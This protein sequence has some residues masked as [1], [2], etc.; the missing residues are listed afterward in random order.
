MNY[1]QPHS[2]CGKTV[3]ITNAGSGFGAACAQAAYT[4]GANIVLIDSG[5]TGISATSKRFDPSRIIC[6][7]ANQAS[8]AEVQEVVVAAT[9]KFGG[10]DIAFAN[11]GSASYPRELLTISGVA[12]PDRLLE[13]GTEGLWNTVR[14]CLPMIKMKNGHIQITSS[15]C[16][17]AAGIANAPQKIPELATK[18]YARALTRELADSGAS[19]GILHPGWVCTPPPGEE[20]EA[21]ALAM[22][23]LD[24]IYHGN[25]NDPDFSP[26]EVC[27]EAAPVLSRETVTQRRF[28]FSVYSGCRNLVATHIR[29]RILRQQAKL[30]SFNRNLRSTTL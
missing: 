1:C 14:A 23:L 15:T 12:L 11:A 8:I 10:I 4:A 25:I 2:L 20:S 9:K 3:L 17:F 19:A 27:A 26:A 16:G 28:P 7:T 5:S 21:F 24:Q 30:A 18:M 22:A 29:N 6:V 13:C